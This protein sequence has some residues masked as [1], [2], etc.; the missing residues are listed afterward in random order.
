M[1]LTSKCYHLIFIQFQ[2]TVILHTDVLMSSKAA[3]S[4]VTVLLNHSHRLNTQNDSKHK[5][6]FTLTSASEPGILVH[7][8]IQRNT[9]SHVIPLQ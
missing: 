2:T 1:L 4:Q 8:T 5:A 3:T 6:A 7:L 9:C